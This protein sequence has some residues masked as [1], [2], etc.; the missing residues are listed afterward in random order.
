MQLASD[1]RNSREVGRNDC[2][3]REVC[4]DVGETAR[5]GIGTTETIGG[6]P[7]GWI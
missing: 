6:V 1:R 5:G 2:G 3:G 4:Q 7:G